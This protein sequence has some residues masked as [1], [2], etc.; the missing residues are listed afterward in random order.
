MRSFYLAVAVLGVAL[1]QAEP[2]PGMI[3]SNL[4]LQYWATSRLHQTS[5]PD[6]SPALEHSVL[7][8]ALT[9]T[10]QSSMTESF[11][12]VITI[13]CRLETP[14]RHLIRIR[15]SVQP[16]WLPIRPICQHSIRLCRYLVE[17]SQ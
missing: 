4:I 16:P 1:V 13:Q 15:G 5:S 3:A 7:F 2:V 10:T 12:G 9:N 6:V 17:V 14:P 8:I 11:A